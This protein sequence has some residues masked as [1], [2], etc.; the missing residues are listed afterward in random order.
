MFWKYSRPTFG[1]KSEKEYQ[2]RI[3]RESIEG[4]GERGVC[5]PLVWLS[6]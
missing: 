3:S 6:L 4:E 5:I 2:G 1:E